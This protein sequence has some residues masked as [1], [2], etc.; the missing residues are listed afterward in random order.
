MRSVFGLIASVVSGIS[1]LGSTRHAKPAW[2]QVHTSTGPCQSSTGPGSP[3][4][5]RC[6]IGP[7]PL[8]SDC[9]MGGGVEACAGC[10]VGSV[11]FCKPFTNDIQTVRRC[12]ITTGRSKIWL[13]LNS[14][15]RAAWHVLRRAMWLCTNAA[16]SWLSGLIHC[17]RRVKSCSGN[18]ANHRDESL[19][20]PKPGS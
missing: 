3:S 12:A 4:S 7:G 2:S 8:V 18:V 11:S 14:G 17:D 10:S 16:S 20:T 15:V 6:G 19:Q 1:R 9:M 5:P 13:T